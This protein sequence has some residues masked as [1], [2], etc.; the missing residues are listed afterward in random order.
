NWTVNLLDSMGHVA[1]SQVTADVDL[2]H[3]GTIEP[4]TDRGQYTFTNVHP[5]M[6]TVQLVLQT[7]YVQV[8]T[9]QK[10]TITDGQF[11]ENAAIGVHLNGATIEGRKFDD[12]Y[13]LGLDTGDVGASTPGLNNWRINLLD[14]TGNVVATQLTSGTGL[15]AGQYAFTNL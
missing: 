11:A 6:Y 2:N 4:Q 1:A 8:T 3:D 9:N 14:A 5:G 10:I 15:N 7:P 13:G 12:V